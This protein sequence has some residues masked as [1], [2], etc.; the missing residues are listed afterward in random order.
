[1]SKK[2]PALTVIASLAMV[3]VIGAG[4]PSPAHADFRVC[5]KTEHTLG[6]ALAFKDRRMWTSLGWWSVE[7]DDCETLVEGALLE[8]PYY[9][10]AEHFDVGGAWEGP[11]LFCVDNG[12]FEITGREECEDRGFETAGFFEIK[13]DGQN[14]LR[15]DLTPGLGHQTTALAGD[16]KQP[17][18]NQD[19][20]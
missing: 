17:A 5:N 1:M 6:L 2:L 3:G 12:S 20:E 13:T 14:S 8:T 19:H 4:L 15:L 9:I 10:H 11:R 7:P 18:S 16:T